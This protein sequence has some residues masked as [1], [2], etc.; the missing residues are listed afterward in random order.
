MRTSLPIALAAWAACK[1]SAPEPQAAPPPR[2]VDAAVAV[3]PTAPDAATVVDETMAKK[4]GNCPS[5]VVGAVTVV[6][7]AGS[8]GHVALD[9]TSADAGAVPAIRLRAAH[10]VDVQGAPP[11]SVQHTGEGTGGGD[12][13]VCPV[14]VRDNRLE[15]AEIDGGVRVTIWPADRDDGGKLRAEIDARIE[16]AKAWTAAHIKQPGEHGGLGGDGGGKGGHGANRTGK[17]DASGPRDRPDAGADA[18]P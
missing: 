5:T 7:G 17:G 15:L 3:T 13:G 6:S 8:D 14:I 11:G 9:I 12:A 18:P 10:L 2:P 4:A 1:T 16:K